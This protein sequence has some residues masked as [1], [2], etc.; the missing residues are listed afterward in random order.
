[1]KNP[2]ERAGFFMDYGVAL[3][4]GLSTTIFFVPQKDFRCTRGAAEL[5]EANP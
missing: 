2:F 1:M 4:A 3:R 5:S